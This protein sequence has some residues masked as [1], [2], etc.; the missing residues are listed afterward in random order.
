M[1]SSPDI[2]PSLLNAYTATFATFGRRPEPGLQFVGFT[3]DQVK[4]YNFHGIACVTIEV[5][6]HSAVT[7]AIVDLHPFQTP[8]EENRK[9]QPPTSAW[10]SKY[11]PESLMICVASGKQPIRHGALVPDES[12]FRACE[13]LV[14]LLRDW[15]NHKFIPYTAKLQFIY[16]PKQENP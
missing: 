11:H 5:P 9:W 12:E 8:Q 2:R 1:T 15:N 13:G 7:G 3:K 4:R 14:V 6:R 16:L 10:V